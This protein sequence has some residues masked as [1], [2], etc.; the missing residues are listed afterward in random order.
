MKIIKI[1]LMLLM[2]SQISFCAFN[3]IKMTLLPQ[4][5]NFFESPEIELVSFLTRAKAA[6]YTHVQCGIRL[7]SSEWEDGIYTKPDNVNGSKIKLKSA[8]KLC[9]E[10]GMIL[11]PE[12]SCGSISSWNWKNVN[13]PNIKFETTVLQRQPRIRHRAIII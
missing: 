7:N 9:E 11:V 3:S 10:N 6:G 5:L 1:F 13:N 12:I 8:I 4:N 2:Y